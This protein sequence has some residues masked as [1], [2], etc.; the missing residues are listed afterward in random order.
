MS[1]WIPSGVVSIRVLLLLNVP[2]AI[3]TAIALPEPRLLS[4]TVRWH[5]MPRL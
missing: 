2:G 1:G 4:C 3:V 5:M